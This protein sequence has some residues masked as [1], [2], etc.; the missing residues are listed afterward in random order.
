MKMK[1]LC[2]NTGRM[3]KAGPTLTP[4]GKTLVGGKCDCGKAC[5][6][7]DDGGKFCRCSHHAGEYREIA[8]LRG[9]LRTEQLRQDMESLLTGPDRSELRNFAHSL[10]KNLTEAEELTQATCVKAFRYAS[11]YDA[12]RPLV[13]WLKAILRNAFYDGVRHS[14]L[15]LSLD[16][17]ADEGFTLGDMLA[18]PDVPADARIERAGAT[19]ALLQAMAELPKAVRRLVSLCDMEGMSYEAAASRLNVP[20]GTVRSRLARG[21]RLL[22]EAFV[23]LNDSVNRWGNV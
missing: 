11:V 2:A 23:R 15:T 18:A 17:E 19:Q 1:N 9:E 13:G 12:R 3:K 7:R 20:L 16:V 8:E 6:N 5:G 4:D 14:R 21:R 10:T 22:R